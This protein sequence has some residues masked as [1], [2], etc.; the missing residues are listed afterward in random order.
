MALFAEIWPPGEILCQIRF[1]LHEMKA[2]S[3][4]RDNAIDYPRSPLGGEEI[5][6]L[7]TFKRT[8]SSGLGG[9]EK[10]N[11]QMHTP[12]SPARRARKLP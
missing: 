1:H 11:K 8:V 5:L 3:P 10:I 6:R 4:E 7:T 12:F 2:S 9:L